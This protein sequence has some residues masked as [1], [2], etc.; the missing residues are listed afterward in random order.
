MR[1]WFKYELGFTSEDAQIPIYRNSDHAA[2]MGGYDID[3]SYSDKNLLFK[4][5][6]F[7][8]QYGRLERYYD[9]IL[10][11]FPRIQRFYR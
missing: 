6:F 9:F 10:K 7:G 2:A 5:Y 11:K 1:K 8:F 4:K 3:Q